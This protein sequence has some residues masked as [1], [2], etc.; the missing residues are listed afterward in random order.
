MIYLRR[1]ITG[2]RMKHD[3]PIPR[4]EYVLFCRLAYDLARV[5]HGEVI[6]IQSDN[7][8]CNFYQATFGCT[9]KRYLLCNAVYPILAWSKEPIVFGEAHHFVDVPQTSSLL[10]LYPFFYCAHAEEL[11]A[12]VSRDDMHDLS[13]VERAQAEY[14]NAQ[15]FGDFIFHC[16]D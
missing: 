12:H 10:S 16:W 7:S 6:S 9:S 5:L 4:V 1:G 2:F 3:S 14:W 8:T 11:H 15:T 13:H